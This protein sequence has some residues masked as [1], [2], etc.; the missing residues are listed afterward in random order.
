[1][2]NIHKKGFSAG[3]QDLGKKSILIIPLRG[4]S[5][6]LHPIILPIYLTSKHL[7][8]VLCKSSTVQSLRNICLRL[9]IGEDKELSIVT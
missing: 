2:S 6:L 1:M 4:G 8:Y 5:L 7:K 9:G 3:Y